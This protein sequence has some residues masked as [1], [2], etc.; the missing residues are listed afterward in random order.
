MANA[1]LFGAEFRRIADREHLGAP[2]IV[3]VAVRTYATTPPDLWEA[4]TTPDRLAR[5][6]TT[7]TGDL[8]LGGRYQ[9]KG[10]AEGTITKCEP[11]HA[12]DLTWE[13]GGATSW[14]TVR[15]E[16]VG[17]EFGPGATGVG[18]D[19]SFYGLDM[20]LGAPETVLD[21][22]AAERWLVSSEGKQFVRGS[23]EAWAHAHVLYGEPA[24]SAPPCG[25]ARATCRRR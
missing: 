25:Q 5:W 6:F 10:N 17:A 18:W 22:E 16:K 21:H 9:L 2:A 12:L 3:A 20:H 7:V 23:G 1:S 15:L 24:A 14:V 19:L 8:V 4:I 11:P 13:F